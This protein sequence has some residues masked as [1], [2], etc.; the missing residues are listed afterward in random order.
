MTGQARVFG[1]DGRRIARRDEEDIERPFCLRAW[2]EPALRPAEIE[3]AERLMDEH[4]PA[5]GADEPRNR[6]AP[7]VSGQAITTLATHHSIGRTSAIE[8]R[9]AFAQSEQRRVPSQKSEDP[10]F[11]VDCQLLDIFSRCIRDAERRR[12]GRYLNFHVSC[13]N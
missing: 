9:P 4:C 2:N 3:S 11:R 5:R 8:L 6:H 7:A 12:V 1:H 13:P 10:G